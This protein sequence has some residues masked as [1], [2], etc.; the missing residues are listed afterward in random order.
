MDRDSEAFAGAPNAVLEQTSFLFGTNATYIEALYAQYLENP[1]AVD[2][3][4]RA[5]FGTLGED[6]LSPTQLGR[7]PAWRRDAQLDLETGELTSALTGQPEP[8]PG[9]CEE[10][11]REQMGSKPR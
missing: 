9:S 6:G 8:R 10:W 11:R 1:D 7:G 3:S 2:P 5:Y 4:W